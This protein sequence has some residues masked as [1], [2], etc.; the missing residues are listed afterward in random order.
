MT[1]IAEQGIANFQPR[2]LENLCLGYLKLAEIDPSIKQ[3]L[4]SLSR[5]Q[6]GKVV[7][8]WTESS[9]P[10]DIE[11]TRLLVQFMS[12]LCIPNE[13]LYEWLTSQY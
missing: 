13:L 3:N 11:S 1:R 9:S 7:E 2:M 4:V 6:L 5:E 8:T 12:K 10:S